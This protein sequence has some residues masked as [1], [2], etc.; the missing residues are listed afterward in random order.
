MISL[1]TIPIAS[2]RLTVPQGGIGEAVL[3]FADD[4]EFPAT[5]DE[6]DTLTIGETSIVGTFVG[7]TYLGER[8][9]RFVFGANG[10]G[11]K[12]GSVPYHSDSGVKLANVLTGLQGATGETFDVAEAGGKI[13]GND[14]VRPEDTASKIL[15]WL[16]GPVW[17]VGFDGVTHVV[18]RAEN[19]PD[20]STYRVLEYNAQRER[21]TLD[22][23][24]PFSV[25][26][27]DTIKIGADSR[28]VRTL[29]LDGNESTL[30]IKA[31]VGGDENSISP[32]ADALGKFVDGRSTKRHG[33]YRYRFVSP[34]GVRG[35]FQ[36]VNDPGLPMLRAC[37]VWGSGGVF[38][39]LTAGVHVGMMFLDGDINQPVVTC[40]GG[41]Y[42]E[43]SEPQRV[44]IGGT[45]GSPIASVGDTVNVYLPASIPFTGLYLG[46]PISGTLTPLVA[47]TGVLQGGST[48]GFVK[49]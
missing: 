23:D 30:T 2:M 7:G 44:D 47:A 33:I 27:G 19:T 35:T 42:Q 18:P 46:L 36:P 48:K 6:R 12:V 13:V 22:V 15:T 9:G 41:A 34:D 31:W 29:T 4:V 49:K 32:E 20:E 11:K 37:E 3:T 25:M 8:K 14:F 28:V 1:N 40:V 5:D 24:E 16:V 21:A 43:N 26:V 38:A 45:G 10:W 17:Y 39:T